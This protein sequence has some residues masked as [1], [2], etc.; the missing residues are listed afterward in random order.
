MREHEALVIRTGAERLAD[1]AR[2]TLTVDLPDGVHIEPHQPAEPH[3]IPTVVDVDGLTDM[4]VEYPEPVVKDLGWHDARLVVLEGVVQFVITGL[5]PEDADR[6][7]G[8]LRYQPCIGGACLPP[9][10]IQWSAPLTCS[11][12]YSVLRALA[13]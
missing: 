10:T 12:A 6:V 3:L 7:S 5:I 2:I 8:S 4:T 11:T 13:A 9:R 1:R